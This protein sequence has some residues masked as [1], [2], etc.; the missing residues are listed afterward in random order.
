MNWLKKDKKKIILG[1]TGSFGSGKSTVARILA[2]FG[3]QVI[4][5]DR[6]AHRYLLK[7]SI[8]YKKIRAL[9]G[10]DILKKDKSIDRKKLASLAFA[11][12]A[13]L[14]KLNKIIHPPVVR[15]IKKQIKS[16]RSRII[17]LDAPLLI[18]AGL[19]KMVDRLIVVNISAEEQIKRIKNKYS[20]TASEILKRIRSQIPLSLKV[21]LADFAIDNNG[22][23]KNTRKQLA[24]IRRKLWKN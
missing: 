20:L 10:N 2:S 15:D 3:G 7:G 12:K 24:G 19:K 5:A 1:V 23:L 21:R 22:S 16:S 8:T 4:D 6:I 14:N 13:L 9:F 11:N 18:E 17:I